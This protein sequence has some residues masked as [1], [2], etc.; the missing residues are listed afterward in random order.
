MSNASQGLRNVELYTDRLSTDQRHKLLEAKRR[1]LVLTA[2]AGQKG[3]VALEALAESVATREYGSD[4]A[5][6][7]IERVEVTLHHVHL[8][9]MDD[10]GVLGYDPE[11]NEVEPARTL[12]F[13]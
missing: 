13:E 4:C 12:Q 6:A 7:D 8:P 3:Q 9:K 1:R 11:T 2:L 10:L 5:D